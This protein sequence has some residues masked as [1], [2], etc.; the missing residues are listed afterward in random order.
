M[1]S[2]SAKARMVLKVENGVREVPQKFAYDIPF[3]IPYDHPYEAFACPGCKAECDPTKSL[4]CLQCGINLSAFP[5]LQ[6][7]TFYKKEM[8][9]ETD[10]CPFC[11]ELSVS[12]ESIEEKMRRKIDSA[13]IEGTEMRP[14]HVLH[15]WT[16]CRCGNCDK[17]W[18]DHIEREI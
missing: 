2:E 3:I 5:K 11:G 12:I 14:R 8:H 1:P 16:H 6:K 18:R 9:R 15:Q 10:F 17:A 7:K 4:F 13:A